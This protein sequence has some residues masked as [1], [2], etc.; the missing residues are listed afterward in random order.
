MGDE[1]EPLPSVHVRGRA[2]CLPQAA[3]PLPQARVQLAQ[4]EHG[5]VVGAAAGEDLALDDDAAEMVGLGGPGRDELAGV[6]GEVEHILGLPRG[7]R[8]QQR[9]APGRRQQERAPRHRAQA[10]DQRGDVRQFG[11][12]VTGDG[13][14]DLDLQAQFPCGLPGVQCPAEHSGHAA[15]PVMDL[16]GRAV[17]AQRDRPGPGLA[18]SGEAA[19]GQRGRAR[20]GDRGRKLEPDA[21]PD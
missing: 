10:V 4:A 3:E 20:R 19:G 15:E 6:V 12:V 2:P 14:V 21:V 5:D 18:Q 1:H 11:E 16:R 9:A 13:G 7:Q 17:Q 8:G